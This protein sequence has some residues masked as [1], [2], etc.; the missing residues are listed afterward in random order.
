VFGGIFIEMMSHKGS[1]HAQ[2]EAKIDQTSQP[3]VESTIPKKTKETKKS[4]QD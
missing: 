2:P 1:S 4:K 3:A